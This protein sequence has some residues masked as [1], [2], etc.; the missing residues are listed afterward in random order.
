MVVHQALRVVEPVR[1]LDHLREQ[2][3]KGRTILVISVDPRLRVP[4][5][6]DMIQGTWKFDAEGPRHSVSVE[7]RRGEVTISLLCSIVDG[8]S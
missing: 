2:R 3:Q 8:S 7:N 4:T 5:T 6:G 1:P